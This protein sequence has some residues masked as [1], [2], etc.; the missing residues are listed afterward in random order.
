MSDRN[1]KYSSLSDVMTCLNSKQKQIR[2]RCTKRSINQCISSLTTLYLLGAP[3]RGLLTSNEAN[4]SSITIGASGIKSNRE[5]AVSGWTCDNFPREAFVFP[6]CLVRNRDRPQLHQILIV[7]VAT[8]KSFAHIQ[9]KCHL[10]QSWR[11]TIKV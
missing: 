5:G 10:F 2:Y 4:Q 1:T 9:I 11:L 7:A 8:E 6:K 3:Q